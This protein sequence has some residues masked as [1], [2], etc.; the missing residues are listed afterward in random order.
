MSLLKQWQKKH[1][2]PVATAI[3]ATVATDKGKN[4]PTVA[5]VAEIAVA[6]T[7][8]QESN[9]PLSA[10]PTVAIVAG[11]AVADSV[12]TKNSSDT[13]PVT[14]A[15]INEWR[16]KGLS[17]AEAEKMAEVLAERE[18]L[19]D[20]RRACIECQ[21]SYMKRCKAGLSPIGWSDIYTLH[22]C[23]GFKP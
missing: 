14:E 6:T 4:T 23:K 17:D 13:V 3:V 9:Y 11:I 18:R 1:L 12:E 8:K 5:A 10:E 2:Q 20:D 22:R 15:Q 19:L 21:H 16:R 7:Q